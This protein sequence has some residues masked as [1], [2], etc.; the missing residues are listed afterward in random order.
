MSETHLLRRH[1]ANPILTAADFPR[2]VNSA[3]NAGA[4]KFNGQYLLLARVEDLTGS[5]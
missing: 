5:S 3:F 2:P 1:P 4:V